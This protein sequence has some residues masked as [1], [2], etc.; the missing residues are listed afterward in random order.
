MFK[1]L[2]WAIA[3]SFGVWHA[4][5]AAERKHEKAEW[6]KRCDRLEESRRI[7][8]LDEVRAEA[9]KRFLAEQAEIKPA[10]KLA[11]PQKKR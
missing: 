5:A 11:E 9:Q 3:L 7:A 1:N 4:A 2:A 6:V 10:D 8:C